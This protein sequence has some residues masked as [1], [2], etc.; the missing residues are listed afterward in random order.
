MEGNQKYFAFISYKREDDDWAKKLKHKLEHYHLPASLNGRELPKNLRFVFRDIENFKSGNYQIQRNEALDRSKYLIVICS[1]RLAAD[2]RRI[3]EEIERFIGTKGGTDKIFPFIIDGKP[4]AKNK[5]EECFPSALQKLPDNLD[6]IGGNINEEGGFDFAVIKLIAGMLDV[7]NQ[8]LRDE[9]KRECLRKRVCYILL[10]FLLLFFALFI[11]DYNRSTYSYFADYVDCY[12]VPKGIIPLSKE[13]VL[14]RNGS[15]QFEYRRIP[16]G[17]P[18]AYS[19]RIEGVQYVNSSLFPQD[20]IHTEQRDRYPIIE[21]EYNKNTGIVSRNNFCDKR[22]K[23]ILRHILSEHDGGAANIADFIASQEQRGAGFMGS[24][25][26]SMSLEHLDDDQKS[27]NITRFAY[28]RDEKGNLLIDLVLVILDGSTRD[29]GTSYELINSVIIPNL[30]DDKDCEKNSIAGRLYEYDKM[31]GLSKSV[32][33]NNSGTPILNE[34]LYAICKASYDKYGNLTEENFFDVDDRPCLFREGYAKISIQYDDKGNRREESFRDTNDSLCMTCMGCAIIYYKYDKK[35]NKVEEIYCDRNGKPCFNISGFAKSTVKFDSKNNQVEISVFD[36]VG[37]RCQALSGFSIIKCKYDNDGNQI[38]KAFFD[39]KGEPCVGI[40][41]MSVIAMKYDDTGNLTEEA[42]FDNFGKS[43]L[44][45]EGVAKY[46]LKYDSR[47]FLLEKAYYGTDGLLCLC[48]AKYA[49]KCFKYD[50]KGFLIEIMSLGTDRQLCM[51]SEGFAIIRYQYDSKGNVIKKAYFGTDEKPCLN[52][53]G[54]AVRTIKHDDRGNCIEETLYGKDGKPC[55]NLYGVAKYTSKHD[56]IGNAIEITC[57]NLSEKPC[58]N[59]NGFATVK[60]K[61]DNRG[62][63]TEEAYYDVNGR[64]CLHKNGFAKMIFKYDDK[65]NLIDQAVFD[66]DN[67][68]TEYMNTKM[69]RLTYEYDELNHTVI[70]TYYDK[71][72]QVIQKL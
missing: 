14:H 31:G 21:I 54:I 50:D 34:Q 35:G 24:K 2:S 19:W 13:E 49:I 28:E 32:A 9:Y 4:H 61:Y 58:L 62:N 6:N 67:K 68:P 7:E 36:T 47:G 41:G 18:N 11:W 42:Y 25:L 43:C 53:E 30:G 60:F 16:F 48:K 56:A 44:N 26:T 57:L 17:E 66:K 33:I 69:H 27:S 10:A 12:G 65:G 20:I 22:G 15:Y 29:L 40:E 55:L 51:N 5:D 46:M 64:P 59:T 37:K 1:P 72:N 23:I 70:A 8:E 63:K 45:V 39:N 3:D 38:E 52:D 71:D